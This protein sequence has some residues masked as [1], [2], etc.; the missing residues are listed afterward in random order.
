MFNAGSNLGG[1]TPDEIFHIDCK[2]FKAEATSL[3]V[4]QV[5]SVS[6]NELARLKN[7]M[8]PYLQSL[9]PNSGLD[10]LFLMLTNI[11]NESTELLFV[12]HNTREIVQSAFGVECEA[13]SATLPGV[14]SRKKQLMGPLITAIDAWQEAI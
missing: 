11:I 14:V 1:K 3:A 10:M 9:Q 12:G 7:R 13:N 8:L 4:A 2:R 6:T 5:T